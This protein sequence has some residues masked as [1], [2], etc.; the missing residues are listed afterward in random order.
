MTKS[1]IHSWYPGRRSLG[2]V[3]LC[4][5]LL[6]TVCGCQRSVS[7]PESSTSVAR[8]PEI[9]PDYRDCVLPPNI[10]PLNFVV[11]E[12]GQEVRAKIWSD[13]GSPIIVGGKDSKVVIPLGAWRELLDA[14]VGNDVKMDVYVRQDGAWQQFE[15]ITSHIAPDPID[16]HVAYRRI[17]PLHNTHAEMA[18][19]QREIGSF[20]ERT[21]LSSARQKSHCINCHTFVKNKPET[22]I[23][24]ARDSGR[25]RTG[26]I[27]VQDGEATM[28]NTGSPN[29][30]PA[31][32]TSWHPSGELLAFSANKLSLQHHLAGQSRSVVDTNSNLG[33]YTVADNTVRSAGV[34]ADP[35]YLETFPSWSW[36]GKYLYFSRARRTWSL[37]GV[38]AEPAPGEYQDRFGVPDDYETFQYDLARVRYD[39]ESGA[40]GEVET[41]LSAQAFGKSISEPRASPDGR[42][43]L[44]TATQS[45]TFPVYNDDADLWMLE[46]A[47][48]K[49]WRL[50]ANSD[51]CESWHAWSTNG[52]WVLFASK[53][54][55][56]LF[57]RVYFSYIDADGRSHK[58]VALPQ[59][60]PASDGEYLKSY[61][62]P[63]F[64]TGW[65]KVNSEDLLEQTIVGPDDPTPSI[66]VT[67]ATPKMVVPTDQ[68]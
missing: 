42:F 50:D 66:P 15:T 6:M 30:G 33:I 32:Y 63:E 38:S 19:C 51:R 24:H 61:N 57:A 9:S 13:N 27:L 35:D 8:Q 37:E 39:I 65:V 21:M 64:V 49:T 41:L 31:G 43:V 17:G 36:D 14:N 2:G 67:G 53:R 40:W 55:D 68:E 10:A 46:L 59:K 18:L 7:V 1:L 22:M 4:M 48:G 34:I 3:V 5:M 28:V 23:M 29:N 62:A 58:P 54:S 20:E 52:R 44:F 11:A 47:T 25:N 26:M 56:G 12:D 60:D 16:S 45:G